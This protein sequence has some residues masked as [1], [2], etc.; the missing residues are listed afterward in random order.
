MEDDRY[1][2]FAS[3]RIPTTRA[4]RRRVHLDRRARRRPRRR[5]GRRRGTRPPGRVRPQQPRGRPGRGRRL[6][7]RAGAQEWRC[8][9]LDGADERRQRQRQLRGRRSPQRDV[10]RGQPD[11]PRQPDLRR[12][13]LSAGDQPGRSRGGLH[14]LPRDRVVRRRPQLDHVPDPHHVDLPGHRRPGRR[15]RRR[16][17]RLLR[18][19]RLP[20]RRAGQRPEPGRSRLRVQGRRRPPGTP[21][22]WPRAAASARPWAT[23]STRST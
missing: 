18:D 19:A 10:D 1:G 5:R 12:Q 11:R 4:D 3:P 15:L 6:G 2:R 8:D 9:L 23:C 16:G 20:V 22:A 13:R 7:R 14:A 17:Q 21:I